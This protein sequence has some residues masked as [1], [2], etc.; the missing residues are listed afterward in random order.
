MTPKRRPWPE[1]PEPERDIDPV[2]LG[3]LLLLANALAE[4]RV[5][6][7]LQAD[8]GLYADQFLPPPH[9]AYCEE[10][11]FF[12]YTALLKEG[13]VTE[14]RRG[15]GPP[16]YQHWI[17][18]FGG[19]VLDTSWQQSLHFSQRRPDLI[20]VMVSPIDDLDEFFKQSGVRPMH[21]WK[22]VWTGATP[23][24]WPGRPEHYELLWPKSER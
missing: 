6:P 3:N 11:N 9:Q 17:L 13:I 19:I 14:P 22:E 16:C 20:K 24:V 21:G 18:G 5:Y 1:V 8:E 2:K 10:G 15:E 7:R 23:R 12:L 4:E